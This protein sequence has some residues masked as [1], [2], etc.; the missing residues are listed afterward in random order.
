MT[1]NLSRL[2]KRSVF[3]SKQLHELQSLVK[4]Q[5]LQLQQIQE[6]TEIESVDNSRTVTIF[7]I[8]CKECDVISELTS[9]AGN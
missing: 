8:E 4:D 3:T 1:S 6:R 5:V 9:F 2:S 7:E